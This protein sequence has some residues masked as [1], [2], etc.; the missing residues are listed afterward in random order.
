MNIRIGSL[1]KRTKLVVLTLVETGIN[2]KFLK[3]EKLPQIG[4]IAMFLR[5]CLVQL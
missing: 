1:R 2:T 4:K 5:I 3:K